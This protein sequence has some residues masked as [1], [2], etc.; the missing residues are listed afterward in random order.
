MTFPRSLTHLG[1]FVL[2][3]SLFG[4]GSSPAKVE[5]KVTFDGKVIDSGAIVFI[6]MDETQGKAKIGTQIVDGVYTLE[7]SE[8]LLPGKYKVMFNWNKKTGK[9]V[10]IG[11]GA[12]V[13]DETAEGL[14]AK[15]STAPETTTEVKSGTNTLNFDLTSK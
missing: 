11:D 6:P 14:P 7:V 5:G 3:M 2:C 10:P 15:Y 8:G 9:K 1:V 13:R 4:C 12:G